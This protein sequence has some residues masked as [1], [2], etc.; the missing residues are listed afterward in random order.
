MVH[1]LIGSMKTSVSEYGSSQMGNG[2]KNTKD[3]FKSGYARIQMLTKLNYSGAS[4]ED[5]IHIYKQFV[6]GK[7]DFSSVVWHRSLAEKKSQSL[8]SSVS[9]LPSR[10]SSVTHLSCTTQP[11]RWQV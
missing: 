4:I 7:L 8:W 2:E 10:L 11:L 1:L 6:R 3:L 5:L 9:Q